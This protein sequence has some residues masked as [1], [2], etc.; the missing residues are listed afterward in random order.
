MAGQ[1]KALACLCI[2]YLLSTPCASW[3]AP[4]SG[5]SREL[6]IKFTVLGT[7]ETWCS[8]NVT[9]RLSTSN[10]SSYTKNPERLQQ[11]AGRIRAIISSE[12]PAAQ[13][14]SFLGLQGKK[15]VYRAS[16]W[17]IARWR[18]FPTDG[19]GLPIC[20]PIGPACTRASIALGHLLRL[21][22]D[23]AFKD[24]KFTLF[25]EPDS[26]SLVEWRD[27]QGNVG[28]MK[29]LSPG[30]QAMSTV[31]TAAVAD[32]ILAALGG[33]CAEDGPAKAIFALDRTNKLSLRGIRCASSSPS[34]QYL[35]V[36][37]QLDFFYVFTFGAADQNGSAI[38]RSASALAD[39]ILAK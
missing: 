17:R 37:R 7:E 5:E 28:K 4:P 30:P 2:A 11:T 25:L 33:G 19:S 31:P 36:E 8:E 38:F 26:A 32:K 23:A 9:V 12:C 39:S 20:R 27:S 24:V 14:I 3:G 29:M 1:S 13:Q 22:K 6:G 18:L 34:V 16:A 10:A 21:T 35:L 15:E